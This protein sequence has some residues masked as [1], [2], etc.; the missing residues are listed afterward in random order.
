MEESRKKEL[1]FPHEIVRDEQNKLLLLTDASIQNNRNL[2]VHAPTGLGK[3]AATLSP[4]LAYAIKNGKTIMFLTSRHTQHKIAIDTLKAIKKI[5]DVDASCVSIIGKKHMCLQGG[6]EKLYNKDFLEY[7]KKLKEEKKCEFYTNCRSSQTKFTPRG[8]QLIKILSDSPNT[9][10][11]IVEESA[12]EKVCPYEI[13]L[14]VAHRAKVI[15]TDYYYLFHPDIGESFLSKIEKELKDIIVI[16]DEAHNLPYRLK[17]LASEHLSNVMIKR[18]VSECKKYGYKITTQI[19]Y[20]DKI[21]SRL[22][23]E[24]NIGEKIVVKD[25][26]YKPL[27][28]FD[29]ESLIKELEDTASEVRKIQKQSYL[30]SVANFLHKWL[31]PDEGFARIISKKQGFKE[32]LITLS[33]RCLDSSVVSKEII[34]GARSTI[35]MSGTLLPTSMYKELLGVENCQEVVFNDP[36]PKKNRLNLIIPKTTTKFTARN[37]QQFDNIAE[38]LSDIINTVPGNSAVFFPSYFI[39]DKV[40]NALKGVTKTVF[41]EDPSMDKEEKELFLTN[42]KGY[43]DSGAVLLGVAS[44]SFGEGI[45]LPGDFLKAVIVVGLPLSA[46]DLET[47]SLIEYFDKKFKKGWDYGYL[48]PAFNKTLQ[49]AGR[50]IRSET[51][52]GII[53]FLDERFIWPNYKR[54]FPEDWDIEVSTDYKK[55]IEEFFS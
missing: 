17:D 27:Q 18:A 44:G 3:T 8:S 2:I 9:S 47:K 7:C 42:F 28:K 16:I 53:I 49:N 24:I 35:L 13:S 6:I 31:G 12:S 38:I 19:E 48:F 30:G 39:M 52:K 26:F 32:P 45:D 55:L 50:C 15:I 20:I 10:E 40:K 43:K 21:L 37:D 11:K 14:G 5:Y 23:M 51:D 4:A 54:C 36:F 25:E 46:P 22:C 1:L 33:Y 34:N 41:S 29:Y